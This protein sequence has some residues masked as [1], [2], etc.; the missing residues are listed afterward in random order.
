MHHAITDLDAVRMKTFCGPGITILESG[1]TWNFDTPALLWKGIKSNT[2]GFKRVNTFHFL[3]TR[4]F[5][6]T[7]WVYY[8]NPAVIT[9]NGTPSPATGSRAHFC[10]VTER[11]GK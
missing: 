8:D 9:V 11:P 2:T 7:A 10:S 3:D 5:A 6:E 4:I 1:K